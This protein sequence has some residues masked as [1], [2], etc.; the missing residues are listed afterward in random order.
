MTSWDL[1]SFIHNIHEIQATF[2]AIGLV[3]LLVEAFIP[4]FGVAGGTG[5]VLMIVGIILTARTT[6]EALVMIIILLAIV[7]L[8]I[9]VLANS[10]NKGVLSKILILNDQLKHDEGFSATEDMAFFVGREGVATSVLRPAGTGVFDGLRLDVVTDGAFIEK[11]TP[12]RIASVVGRR[13]IVEP[14]PETE[15]KIES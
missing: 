9:A 2:L 15:P 13:I 8:L 5:I 11:G 3:L 6:T 14:M 7:G 1:F 12:I 4:G 10:A